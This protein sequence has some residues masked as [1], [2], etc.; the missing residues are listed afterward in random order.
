M[1]HKRHLCK[2]KNGE[3]VCVALV[4]SVVGEK[5]M[6][7]LTRAC[8]SLWEQVRASTLRRWLRGDEGN[9]RGQC[10]IHEAP[11]N[12]YGAQL[13]SGSVAAVESPAEGRAGS[14]PTCEIFRSP[15]YSA[16]I[17]SV[18]LYCRI[19]FIGCGPP[20]WETTQFWTNDF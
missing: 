19:P 11:F 17:P 12:S 20:F 7:I 5:P 16:E 13:M 18:S 3:G 6:G 15:F 9:N 10:A 14:F 2:G 8:Y 1:G 4:A